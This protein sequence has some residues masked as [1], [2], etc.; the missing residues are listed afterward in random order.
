MNTSE[1]MHSILTSTTITRIKTGIAFRTIKSALT[2]VL[3]TQDNNNLNKFCIF[4]AIQ[5]RRYHFK[6]NNYIKKTKT[7]NKKIQKL[8]DN[9]RRG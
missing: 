6:I 8:R 2:N 7:Y 3:T 1:L 9:I 4:S 5:S